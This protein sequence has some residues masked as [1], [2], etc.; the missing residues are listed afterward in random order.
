MAVRGLQGPKP[1][2]A[3][4]IYVAVETATHKAKRCSS[5][6]FLV[7]T[8]KADSSRNKRAM[9]QSTLGMTAWVLW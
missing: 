1:L 2:L 8:Q 4:E 5:L 9:A 7:R 3:G 6:R